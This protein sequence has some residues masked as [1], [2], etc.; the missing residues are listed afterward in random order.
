ML[1]ATFSG[2][3]RD[4]ATAHGFDGI[5]FHTLRHGAAT[6]LLAS[7]VPDAVAIS[8]MGHADTKILGR[9]QDVVSELQRDAAA[10]MD[11]LLG[12]NAGGLA[13]PPFGY[14]RDPVAVREARRCKRNQALV[15]NQDTRIPLR[16]QLLGFEDVPVL[17]VVFEPLSSCVA[18]P[19]NRDLALE[20]TD[21]TDP[22]H[23]SPYRRHLRPGS[24]RPRHRWLAS[25][26]PRHTRATDRAS[27]PLP[28]AGRRAHDSR[29]RHM[30][31]LAPHSPWHA[32]RRKA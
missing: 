4:F 5:T 30:D 29:G 13:T 3:W 11:V 1:P 12:G 32:Q 26:R 24:G 17:T 9:Y 6:L 28:N 15:E 23:R 2:A 22:C 31:S 7:V 18:Y 20:S 19:A 25:H 14:S 10:R 16:D 27:S 8:V 21:L